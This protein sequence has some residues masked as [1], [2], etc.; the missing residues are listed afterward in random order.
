MNRKTLRNSPYLAFFTK[1]EVVKPDYS[2]DVFHPY[3]STGN[4]RIFAASNW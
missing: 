1:C 4:Y 2:H 3:P